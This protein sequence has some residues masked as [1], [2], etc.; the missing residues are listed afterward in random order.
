MFGGLGIYSEDLFFALASGDVLYF[1]VDDETR[2]DYE[3]AGSRPF[4][5]FEGSGT[6]GYWNV[7][8]D[9]LEDT[10]ELGVWMKKAIAVVSRAKRTKTRKK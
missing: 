5:P 4:Q 6:M 1:K 3:A 2:L 7:P 10:D 9:V 8:A